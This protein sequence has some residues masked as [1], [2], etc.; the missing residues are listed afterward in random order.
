V[1]SLRRHASQKASG[2]QVSKLAKVIE[3]SFDTTHESVYG[4]VWTGPMDMQK[5][6]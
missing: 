6:R 1:L 3:K 5:L 4:G 2:S